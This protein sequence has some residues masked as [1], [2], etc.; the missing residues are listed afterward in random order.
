MIH[1]FDWAKGHI[2]DTGYVVKTSASYVWVEGFK[3]AYIGEVVS[4][5]AGSHGVVTRLDKTTQIMSFSQTALLVGTESARTGEAM[6]VSVGDGLW[7]NTI[8]ALGYLENEEKTKSHETK[9]CPVEVAAGDISTRA[10]INQFC[11]TGVAIVDLMI[12]L[13]KGQRELVQSVIQRNRTAVC[14]THRPLHDI[15]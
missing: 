3:K 8:D 9:N 15:F 7:G 2:K 11:P 6:H 10:E 1:T 12:P 5:A 13:G 14:R 4:F